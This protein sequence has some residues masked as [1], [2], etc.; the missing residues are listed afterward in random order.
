MLHEL[1]L[2]NFASTAPRLWGHC[3]TS[4]KVAG[5]ILDEVIGFS[6]DLIHPSAL[7]TRGLLKFLTEMSTRDLPG[8]KGWSML[9]A[10]TLTANCKPIY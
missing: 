9:M 3:A 8:G 4:R 7:R 10:D 6:I 5:S 1:Y 2:C